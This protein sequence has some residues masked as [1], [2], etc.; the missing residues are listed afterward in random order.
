MRLSCQHKSV[1]AAKQ[2]WFDTMTSAFRDHA[3][4]AV[5]VVIAIAI[6]IVIARVHS[7]FES[8]V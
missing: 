1:S 2:V 6:A 8:A 7:P 4:V 3:V 5:A